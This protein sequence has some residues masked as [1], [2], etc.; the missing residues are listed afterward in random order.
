MAFY[1]G[2]LSDVYDRL[3]IIF[4]MVERRV[5]GGEEGEGVRVTH[6]DIFRAVYPVCARYYEELLGR[7][8][9][10]VLEVYFYYFIYISVFISILKSFNHL[11]KY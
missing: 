1:P 5:K 8:F 11:T 3:K 9:G 10:N 6:L 2:C 7:H 4:E